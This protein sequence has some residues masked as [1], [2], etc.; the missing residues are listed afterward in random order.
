MIFGACNLAAAICFVICLSLFFVLALHPRKFAIL[1]VDAHLSFSDPSAPNLYPATVWDLVLSS[2]ANGVR[3][4]CCQLF[5]TWPLLLRLPLD[6]WTTHA[7]LSEARASGRCS[8]P[9]LSQPVST[10]HPRL[11]Q[12]ALLPSSQATTAPLWLTRGVR[13][14]M[15]SLLFL[16]SWAV[17]LGPITYA[18]HLLSAPRLPFTAVYFGSIAS[19]LYCAIGVS[20]MTSRSMLL[21]ELDVLHT[22]LHRRPPPLLVEGSAARGVHMTASKHPVDLGLRARTASVS[23]M[24]SGQLF[25]H[26]RHRLEVCC[27]LR[28]EQSGGVDDGLNGRW[29]GVASCIMVFVP[30]GLMT[31][32]A[33]MADSVHDM[34]RDV[35]QTARMVE[36]PDW[37]R[38]HSMYQYRIF[39]CLFHTV[40]YK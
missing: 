23:R 11:F 39:P 2:R 14:S 29:A 5:S 9:T 18:K 22:P 36:T 31:D 6:A 1:Y 15:G 13:W 33:D 37:A 12:R 26:G 40:P 21:V 30:G 34:Q 35:R 25:P 32:R 16:T 19:T 3:P 8:R 17:L 20:R 28:H 10:A 24:V 7:D 38:C 4:P 27:P